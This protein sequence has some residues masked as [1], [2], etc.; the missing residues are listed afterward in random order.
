MALDRSKGHALRATPFGI[1]SHSY[2][3]TAAE[4]SNERKMFGYWRIGSTRC[5]T[6][7]LTIRCTLLEIYRTP[8]AGVIDAGIHVRVRS[9]TTNKSDEIAGMFMPIF[10]GELGDP[11]FINLA[12]AFRH[13]AI[14]LFLGR[15]RER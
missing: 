1:L 6:E 5:T 7:I 9:S 10:E 2:P 11:R 13:H 15:A 3:E 12:Q 4:S 14:V 8:P